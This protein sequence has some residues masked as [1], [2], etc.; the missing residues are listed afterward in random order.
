ML[1]IADFGEGPNVANSAA[2]KRIADTLRTELTAATQAAPEITVR[3]T[4]RIAD[5]AAAQRAL[6]NS[7]SHALLW[8]T[9]PQG[10]TGLLSTTLLL[11]TV[12]PGTAWERIG[13]AG[14]LLFPPSIPLPDQELIGAKGLAPLLRAV[15]YYQSGN[16]EAARDTAAGL[17][18]NANP[19]IRGAA[20]FIN[21]NALTAL[22]HPTEAVPLYA[23]LDAGGWSVPAVLNNW[24][25]AS[26]LLGKPADA[27]AAFDR[28]LTA[29]PPPTRWPRRAF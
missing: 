24:G 11:Q 2:G 18:A 12:P 29:N 1:T 17:S 26:D 3:A 8:G 14:R 20:G 28:A 7:G 23:G 25:V 6:T 9:L 22:G 19:A 5:G 15:L 13:T 10:E 16:F 27:L 21:A 4:G